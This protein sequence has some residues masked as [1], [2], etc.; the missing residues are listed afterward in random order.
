MTA[1]AATTVNCRTLVDGTLRVTH[2]IAPGDAAAGFAMCGVPGREVGLAALKPADSTLTPPT[3]G[4]KWGGSPASD[5]RRQLTR[6][7]AER[8]RKALA[9]G[10][11][12]A[13]P[14]H[15]DKLSPTDAKPKGGALAKLAGQWCND[16]YLPAWLNHH[17]GIAI[18][19]PETYRDFC[20]RC[21]LAVCGIQSRADLDHDPT[22]AHL[23][24]TLIREPF[25]EYLKTRAK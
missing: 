9:T 5:A 24:H 22:A 21:I 15:G 3:A 10:P 7:S 16:P 11:F 6:A 19:P 2:D 25:A 23:F 1:I 17:F 18:L 13:K 12:I 4:D 8:M 14:G 20:R